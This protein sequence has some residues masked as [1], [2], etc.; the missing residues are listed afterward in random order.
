V[1]DTADSGQADS[2]SGRLGFL[3]DG[4]EIWPTVERKGYGILASFSWL[5]GSVWRLEYGDGS[6]EPVLWRNER[7]LARRS[8]AYL[9]GF[10]PTADWMPVEDSGYDDFRVRDVIR[11]RG[12]TTQYLSRSD[13]KFA[14]LKWRWWWHDIYVD[15]SPPFTQMLPLIC[16]D[17]VTHLW[18][19]TPS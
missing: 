10:A 3:V 1:S 14:E 17:L 2:W 5:D 7:L 11:W 19:T 8:L 13:I 6:V 9:S 18:F 15:C 12:R 4:T 16:A